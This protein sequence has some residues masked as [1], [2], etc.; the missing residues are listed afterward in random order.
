MP[1]K[2]S[3]FQR[4][5]DKADDSFDKI[6]QSDRNVTVSEVSTRQTAVLT[7]TNVCELDEDGR[8]VQANN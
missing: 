1:K 6:Y 7:L 8:L 3:L 5:V 4:Y 2:C